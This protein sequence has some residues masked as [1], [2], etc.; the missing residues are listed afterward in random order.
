MD[1]PQKLGRLVVQQRK[2]ELRARSAS[3]KQSS[4]PEHLPLSATALNRPRIIIAICA[5]TA[6]VILAT[7]AG[8]LYASGWLPAQFQPRKL[9]IR[10]CVMSKP[11]DV[12]ARVNCTS[13]P[14]Y[15]DLLRSVKALDTSDERWLCGAEAKP[16]LPRAALLTVSERQPVLRAVIGG[17]KFWLCSDG[18]LEQMDAKADHGGAY[19]RIRQLPSI[20]LAALPDGDLPNAD[21]LLVAAACCEQLIPGL[22]DRVALNNDGQLDLYDRK[23]FRVFL[24]EPTDVEA[25]IA[26]LPQALRLCTADRDRLKYLDASNPNLFYQVWKEP[27]VASTT[28]KV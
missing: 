3:R 20:E 7:A 2:Q 18:T 6:V 24:G 8:M 16:V 11:E 21:A 13:Q 12:L 27:Q 4:V 5:W 22:I 25:K 28:G 15:I 26:A 1:K 10:G 14:H 23:G 19:D 9:I 17:A